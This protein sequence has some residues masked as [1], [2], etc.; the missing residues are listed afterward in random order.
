MLVDPLLGFGARRLS[1]KWT[2]KM[3]HRH[4]R[5]EQKKQATNSRVNAFDSVGARKSRNRWIR[6]ATRVGDLFYVED[7]AADG[8]KFRHVGPSTFEPSCRELKRGTGPRDRC[9]K[10][11]RKK[12][13]K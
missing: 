2:P 13:K 3:R 7:N 10:K 4:E 5:D 1:K 11:E 9:L 12:K 6:D 8:H